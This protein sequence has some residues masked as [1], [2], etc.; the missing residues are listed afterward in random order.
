MSTIQLDRVFSFANQ[1]SFQI[2]SEW[3]EDQEEGDHYLYH[4]PN[5]DSGW[6]RVSLITLKSPGKAS[7]ERVRAFLIKK[8]QKVHGKLYD[9]GSNIVVAWEQASK[10][11]GLGS[12]TIG[13]LSA[14][15]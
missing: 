5:T 9:Y 11:G 13:G 3:V 1:L 4:A 12:A 6:L 7:K 14:I 2:P 8:T 15:A 10:Q